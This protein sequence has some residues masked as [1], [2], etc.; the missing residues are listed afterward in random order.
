MCE[1]NAECIINN[2][3]RNSLDNG[4]NISQCISGEIRLVG[5]ST[6]Y[7]GRA[8]FCIGGTWTALCGYP[9]SWDSNDAAVLCN[10]F[11]LQSSGNYIY[12]SIWIDD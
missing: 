3:F 11:G 7:E 5:G 12:R 1:S 6:N 4:L 9:W 8:E 2:L 10:Q